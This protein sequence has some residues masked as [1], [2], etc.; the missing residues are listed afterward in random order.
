MFVAYCLK[1]YET[2]QT[3]FNNTADSGFGEIDTQT[4]ISNPPRLQVTQQRFLLVDQKGAVPMTFCCSLIGRKT[5]ATCK[6]LFLANQRQAL[7][8]IATWENGNLAIGNCSLYY[9]C[10]TKWLIHTLK[11]EVPL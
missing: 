6:A 2:K 7:A 1:T 8:I 10:E 9:L 11:Q 4:T 3:T 5:R